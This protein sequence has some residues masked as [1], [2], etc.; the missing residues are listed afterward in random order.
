MYVC[1]YVFMYVCMYVYIQ[2]IIKTSI[3]IKHCLAN[4]MV[5]WARKQEMFQTDNPNC[6]RDC[7]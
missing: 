1:M 7:H 2:G 5:Q 3:V 6:M 4:I